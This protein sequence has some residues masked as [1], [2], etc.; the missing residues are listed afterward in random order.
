MHTLSSL[1][2]LLLI[3]VLAAWLGLAAGEA[4]YP[5]GGN[6]SADTE[7]VAPDGIHEPAMGL[8]QTELVVRTAHGEQRGIEVLLSPW[9][10][11]PPCEPPSCGSHVFREF[12]AT[13]YVVEIMPRGNRDPPADVSAATVHLSDF[14]TISNEKTF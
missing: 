7:L 6:W 11:D 1:C 3:S 12:G 2:R 14:N 9:E 5:V 13:G 8:C 4:P 10:G